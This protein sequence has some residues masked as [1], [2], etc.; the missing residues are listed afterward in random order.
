MP[1]YEYRCESCGEEFEAHQRITEDPL[2]EHA[3]CGGAVRRLISRT[4]FALRGDGWYSDHYGLK[5]SE[6][7]GNGA[8]SDASAKES[9]G[10]SGGDGKSKGANESAGKKPDAPKPT[11][12]D[13]S[14][15]A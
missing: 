7:G 14:K 8:S 6:N 3:D 5:K 9:T 11:P 1:I 13:G 2:T 15:A 4:S 10:E 12:G